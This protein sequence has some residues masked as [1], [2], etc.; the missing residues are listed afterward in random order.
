VSPPTTAAV[1]FDHTALLALG[2]G[3]RL[4][5][6]LVVAAH[7]Q[8]GRHV[9]AP[10]LCLAAAVAQRP[11]LADHVG[12]LPALEVLDLGYAAASSVGHLISSGTPWQDAHAVDAARP[13]AEWPTGLPVATTTP[14]NYRAQGPTIP[15]NQ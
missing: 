1:V 10:A 13:S 3:S 2:S 11:A 14:E 7:G 5:S 9:Y 15:L 4:A 12:G 8:T 6:R